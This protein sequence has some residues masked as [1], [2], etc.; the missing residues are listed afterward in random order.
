[1]NLIRH[2][3]LFHSFNYFLAD[4]EEMYLLEVY[5]TRIQVT[6]GRANALAVTNHYQ[7]PDLQILHGKRM[8]QH[9]RQRLL[10]L[11]QEA[12]RC[13]DVTGPF[14]AIQEVMRDHTA[15]ICGHHDGAATLWS[16]VC[17]PAEHRLAY[18]L[19]APCRN[20]YQDIPWPGSD[21][22]S[23]PIP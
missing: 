4:G 18:A 14:T 17:M 16:V 21:W 23:E 11:R 15:P 22:G 20:L 12:V 9:S 2:M 6:G 10:H 1:M 8:L 3:P 13:R 7:H 19:G 5:P